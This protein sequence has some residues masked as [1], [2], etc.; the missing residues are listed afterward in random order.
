MGMGICFFQYIVVEKCQ[1]KA[2]KDKDRQYLLFI[3]EPSIHMP[4]SSM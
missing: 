4:T 3:K 1:E 2:P